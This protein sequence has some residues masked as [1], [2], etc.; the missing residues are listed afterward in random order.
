MDRDEPEPADLITLQALEA[1]A[2]QIADEEARAEALGLALST[3]VE[4]DV[5]GRDVGGA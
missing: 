1:R 2:A 4:S 5:T 3:P